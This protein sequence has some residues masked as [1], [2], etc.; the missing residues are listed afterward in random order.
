MERALWK[1][2]ALGVLVVALAAAPGA[3]AHTAECMPV[4]A[5]F[6]ESSDWLRLA[7]GLAADASACASY[8]VTIPALAADKTQLVNGRAPQVRALGP[9]FHALAEINYAAWSRWVAS[10]GNSWYQAGTEARRRMNAAGFD[11]SSGDTWAV[12]EFPSTVR[13]NSG[14][15][16]QNVRD[17][18]HGLY[19]GDGGP[20]VKG[21][22]YV[23]GVG[24]NGLSFPAYKA[25][26]ESWLQDAPFWNDM[27]TYV[28][29]FYQEAYGD[30]RNYAVAGVDPATR[31]ALLN[32][33]LQHLL[34]LALAANAP[35]TEG[36][37]RAYLT[38]AYAPL[39]NASWGWASAYGWTQ[40]TPD[41]MA[42]YVSSQTYAIRLSGETHIGFAWNPL[43]STSLSAGDYASG[44]AGVLARLAGS[45]HETDAG[46]PSVACEA[47]GCS[48]TLDGAA[49]A[50]G[51]STFSTWTPTTATFTSSPV[52]LQTGAASGPLTIQMQTGGVATTLP[53]D[54]MLSLTSTSPTG[55]L[56]TSATGPFTSTLSLPI[57][58]GTNTATFYF[59]DTTP[60]QPTITS[61]L[62]GVAATQV[63]SVAAPV[64]TAPPPP[65]PPPAAMVNSLTYTPVHDRLHV[66]MQ[67]LDTTGQPLE[68]TVRFAILFSDSQ[69][70]SAAVRSASDGSVG[71]T[72]F[73]LLQLGCYSVHVQRVTVSGHDWNGVSPTGTYCVRWLPASVSAIA[74]GKRNGRLHLGVHVVDPAGHPLAARVAVQVLHR[75][76]SFTRAAGLAGTRGWFSITARPKLGHGE[77]CYTARVTAVGA[78]GYRWDRKNATKFFCLKH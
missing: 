64:S 65:P 75:G 47:T 2:S 56:S 41:V 33:F 73:P 49:T 68:G 43:N 5:V 11:I 58:A 40:V 74:F 76:R 6:Y 66:A 4:Q 36:A 62:N 1:A 38:S 18:V 28:S 32:S 15:A 46:D 39:A 78:P 17:L 14:A 52:T 69:I 60:G 71:I 34:S 61:N 10:T 55:T 26:L 70:A 29:G 20:G 21:V 54:S 16:R 30:V 42:D 23:I 8:Y 22:V 37:A 51:W 9:S 13:A 77:S 63:E 19:D 25:N 35:P 24:Q 59:E 48:A 31:A 50:P 67:L 45:I 12:N 57:Q 53:F 3:T 27:A 44:I 72:A 7:N